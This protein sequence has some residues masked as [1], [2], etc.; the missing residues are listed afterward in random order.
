MS[1][2]KNFIEKSGKWILNTLDDLSVPVLSS[3]ASMGIGLLGSSLQKQTV[4]D[5]MTGAE[6]EA[7]EF[8]ANE[9]QKVRDFNMQMDNTKYQ[10]QVVDMQNAGI[11]PALAMNGGV[12]T[13]ATSNAVGHASTS[14]TPM[15]SV[16]DLATSAANLKNLKAQRSLIDAQARLA[17]ANAD[18]VDIENKYKD[19]LELAIAVGQENANNLTQA[20]INKINQDIE[21]ARE[22]INLIKQQAKTEEERQRAL[23]AQA[24]VDE[25]NAK[26]IEAL[27]PVLVEL[28]KAE[29]N[30]A[31][32]R[33]A[34]SFARAA[35]QQGLIDSGIIE[36]M[37]RE[38]GASADEAESIALRISG[39]NAKRGLTDEM[40]NGESFYSGGFA[41]FLGTTMWQIADLF[42]SVLH[43]GVNFQGN[44]SDSRSQNTST[45]TV[46]STSNNTNTNFGPGGYNGHK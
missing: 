20:N 33:A 1:K 19:R 38:Q 15:M 34:E 42:G 12:S 37:A 13:Q 8:N 40:S 39:E 32:A 4:N 36:S 7:A 17:N 16:V 10:R 35:Y 28:R 43:V 46:K 41:K 30:E 5:S 31:K 2:F 25:A 9:A 21:K 45:S 23:K 22:E 24:L 3:V 14:P 26:Q 11:N 27:T 44:T 29:T 18:A 6:R